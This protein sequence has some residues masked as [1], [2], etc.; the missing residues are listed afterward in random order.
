MI[1]R[2]YLETSALL[3]ALLD[4]DAGVADMI[5]AAELRCASELTFVEAAR[6]LI[7]ARHTGRLDARGAHAIARDL[8]ALERECDVFAVSADVLRRAR[9][10]LPVEPVRTLDAIH[11]ATIRLIDAELGDVAVASFDARV[12]ANVDAL[13]IPLV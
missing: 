12:R 3:R 8:A 2:V 4:G 11:L 9:E 7:R 1:A 13:G 5:D 10:P 6:A